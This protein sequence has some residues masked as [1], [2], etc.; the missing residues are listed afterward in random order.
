MKDIMGIADAAAKGA[1]KGAVVAA[2]TS[3]VSG[4]AMASVPVKVLGLI[5]VGTST[6]VA[7][8]VVASA[9]ACGAL[10]GGALAAYAAY[11]KQAKIEKL[12]HDAIG[13]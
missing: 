2:A 13:D 5:T 11:R 12:F 6:V 7:A 10:V 4:Y 3:I 8:P 1:S 9:A